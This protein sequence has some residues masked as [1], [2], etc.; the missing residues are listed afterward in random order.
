MRIFLAG[1]TGL[2]GH[3]VLMKLRD[4]GH[5]VIAMTRN[6]G[7]R[8]LLQSLGVQV[9]VMDAFDRSAIMAT[10]MQTRPE[11]V[12]H[13]LTSLRERDLRENARLRMDGTRNLVD[14][15]LQFGVKRI[16]AQ[17][18]AWA[19]APGDGPASE[20]VSLDVDAVGPRKTTIDGVVALEHAVAEVP[21]H[22]ILRYGVFYGPGTWY[23]RDGVMAEAIRCGQLV[24][25]DGVTSFVHI[26][27]AANAALLAM[28]W[29]SGPVNIVDD[30]PAAGIDWL[31]V[32]AAAIGA[33]VPHIQ[34]KGNPWERGASNAK[35]RETYGWKPLYPTWRQ[36]FAQTLTM[37]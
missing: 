24:A 1:S 23:D 4:A 9:V 17:S 6:P 16:I 32:Y 7:N 29:P 21:Q 26:Q 33:P 34:R 15:S 30:E 13:Q 28:G 18:I 11:V 20:G 25:T 10:F 14:A 12:I 8:K 36:G 19:Y 27:D 3:L 35:A 31:P 22:V 5:Q 37:H 2:V